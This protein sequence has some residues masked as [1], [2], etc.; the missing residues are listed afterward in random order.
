VARLDQA[1]G[2]SRRVLNVGAGAGSYE[3]TGRDVVAVEPSTVMLAQRPKHAAPA[4]RGLAEAL[5]CPDGHFD[6]A[7][8]ILTL[9]H[10]TDATAGL[11]ELRRV[12]R[13]QVV[14][15]FEPGFR[16]WLTDEYLPQLRDVDVGQVPTVDE[17][18][19]AL[20]G[21]RVTTVTVPQDCVDGFF[22]AYWRRPEAYLER[23][24]RD[25]ISMFARLDDKTVQPGLE[26]LHEDVDSGAWRARHADLLDRDELDAGYRLIVAS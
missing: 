5:P 17:V 16:W 20:G 6:A 9:Q 7:L 25:A 19:A 13:R 4:V 11:R 24:V 2:A 12:A 10:W 23:S 26:R 15:H 8:A 18:V 3:P 21:G 1:L 22:A 14:L